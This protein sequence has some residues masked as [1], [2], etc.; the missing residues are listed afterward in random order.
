MIFRRKALP[1]ALVPAFDAYQLVLEEIEPAKA[2]LTDVLPGSRLPGHPL[3]DALGAFVAR[4]DRAGALMTA[5]RRPELGPVWSACAAGLADAR[6][7]AAGLL[8]AGSE[9]SGFGELLAIVERLLDRLEPFADAEAR[10]AE[11]RRRPTGRA[12]DTG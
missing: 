10:F 5:W 8:A 7:D 12:E 6:S 11:L 1:D 4:L 3:G 2:A 9:P